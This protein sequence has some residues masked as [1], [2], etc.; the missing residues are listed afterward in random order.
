VAIKDNQ[1]VTNLPNQGLV[2]V[3]FVGAGCLLIHRTLIERLPP[4][5]PE[6]GKHWFDWKVDLKGTGIVPEGECMSEDFTLCLHLRRHGIPVLL[7]AGIRCRHV[8]HSEAHYGGLQPLEA[9]PVT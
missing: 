6:A 4:Q 2:E 9:N 5:R 8:G 1:W 7:D 3:D